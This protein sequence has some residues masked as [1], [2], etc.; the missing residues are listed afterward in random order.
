MLAG[1]DGARLEHYL[2]ALERKPRAVTHAAVV[3][4]LPAVFQE[5]RKRLCAARLDGYRE[6]C[7]VLLL[8]REFPSDLVK[9]ALDTAVAQGSV[10]FTTIRQLLLNRLSPVRPETVPVPTAFGGYQVPP[11]M[12]GVTML[13]WRWPALMTA[14]EAAREA[15]IEHFCRQLKLPGLRQVYREA[16]RQARVTGE[17]HLSF[18]AACLAHELETRQKRQLARRLKQA[19][20]P[21]VKGLGDFDFTV[22][23]R[24]PKPEVL[25]L[26]YG[27]FIR[28]RA[29]VLCVGNP[30]TGKTHIGIALGLA[31]LVWRG[32]FSGDTLWC[33]FDQRE[34]ELLIMLAQKLYGLDLTQTSR[35]ALSLDIHHD[36]LTDQP[37]YFAPLFSDHSGSR[38]VLAFFLARHKRVSPLFV[39]RLILFEDGG[40]SQ[41]D[42]TTSQEQELFF[43]SVAP[44]Q[45][46]TPAMFTSQ[47]YSFLATGNWIRLDVSADEEG[48]RSSSLMNWSSGDW[49][50][51]Q[52]SR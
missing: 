2:D 47:S 39:P 27:D 29:N 9:H 49:P 19:R 40:L 33:Y 18:L 12:Q 14:T 31:C 30:G 22:L 36:L 3:R 15:L 52:H 7:Q 13:C 4:E 41:L 45:M 42:A 20:F 16:A 38:R 1:R 46:F 26:A 43:Q 5:V 48:M 8:Y 35:G 21:W 23:P 10:G 28:R 50:K 37:S 32:E 6:F 44:T 11:L 24:L 17:D 34:G 51:S 25:A